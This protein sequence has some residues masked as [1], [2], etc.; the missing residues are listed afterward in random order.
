MPRSPRSERPSPHADALRRRESPQSFLS[1]QSL[2]QLRSDLSLLGKPSSNNSE[3]SFTDP[4]SSSSAESFCLASGDQGDKRKLKRKGH[5]RCSR[6]SGIAA[7]TSQLG[8]SL[9][10]SF[11]LETPPTERLSTKAQNPCSVPPPPLRPLGIVPPEI[12]VQSTSTAENSRMDALDDDDAPSC[13]RSNLTE[14]NLRLKSKR[15]IPSKSPSN[16]V[17][18]PKPSPNHGGRSTHSKR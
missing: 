2:P 17:P 15:R 16:P 8:S 11:D 18:P 1:F 13:R 7:T 10:S 9:A 14:E 12:E 4:D 6:L 5:R 3:L